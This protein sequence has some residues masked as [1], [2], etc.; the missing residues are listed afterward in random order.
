MYSH[1]DCLDNLY[2]YEKYKDCCNRKRLNCIF[3]PLY[4]E[5]LTCSEQ[6]KLFDTFSDKKLYA[7]IIEKSLWSDNFTFSM[8]SNL[9]YAKADA[10]GNYSFGEIA[11]MLLFLSDKY[12][13]ITE[14]QND[15]IKKM[16]GVE[17]LA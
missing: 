15:N 9:E 6:A 1:S 3:K 10:E 8:Y 7:E 4:D 16:L 5:N 17:N 13:S 14:K 11:N 12:G 2:F